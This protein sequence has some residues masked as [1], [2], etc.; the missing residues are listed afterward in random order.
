MVSDHQA[1]LELPSHLIP[2]SQSG[3]AALTY[4]AFH[5]PLNSHALKV[6]LD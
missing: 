5:G 1:H 6:G 2:H 3:E 4:R